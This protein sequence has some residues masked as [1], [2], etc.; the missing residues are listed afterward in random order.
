M[1]L[2]KRLLTEIDK[3][4]YPI[5][6][7][8]VSGSHMYGFPS[9]DSDFDVKGAH[10]LPVQE[11]LGLG[12]ARQTVKKLCDCDG[13]ELDL[14]TH[15]LRKY[16]GLL[17]QKNGN[18]LE[19]VLSP[20]V[21]RTCPEHQ[22]LKDIARRCITRGHHKHYCGFARSQWKLFEKDHPRRVKPLLYVYRVLLVGIH[23]MRTGEVESS[24]VKL[25]EIFKLPYISDLV[26]AKV[27]GPERGVLPDLEV[28]FHQAEYRRLSDKLLEAAKTSPLPHEPEGKAELNDLL[29]RL[30][31]ASLE[32]DEI[33]RSRIV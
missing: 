22:E 16:F 17:L 13:L 28:S 10:A 7:L 27:T 9:S 32:R 23:L 4:P 20:L 12:R 2:D 19:Q 24:I 18:V 3:H 25:N 14:V 11:V 5:V 15:D 33:P 26:A 29:L 6:F 31:M 1:R 30:R 21:V 8:V